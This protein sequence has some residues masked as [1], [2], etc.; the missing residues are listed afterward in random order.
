MRAGRL[1]VAATV[2]FACAALAQD[3]APSLYGIRDGSITYTLVHKLHEVRGTT[4]KLEG[5]AKIQ[6][7]APTLVQVRAPVASFDSGN[8]NRDSHMREATHEAAHPYVEVKG[9]LPPL[10]LPLTGPTRLPLE[11]KVELNGETERQTIPVTLAPE[12]SG[13]RAKFSFPVSLDAHHVERPELLLVKVDD[14]V[15]IEGDVLFEVRK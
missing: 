11:A 9:T 15:N 14:K 8:S 4:H 2:A 7:G 6:P 5:L 10:Q 3:T 1:V 13:I 12:G